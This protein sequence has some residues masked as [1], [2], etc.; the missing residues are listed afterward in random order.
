M[1]GYSWGSWLVGGLI[2]LLFW[3]GLIALVVFSIRAFTGANRNK[4][5]QT[6]SG[7]TALDILKRR[8]AQGE[9][10]QAEYE[11]IRRDIKT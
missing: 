7:E 5:T 4:P 8:Y 6:P 9:I 10:D 2:M 1:M 11:A 3:G